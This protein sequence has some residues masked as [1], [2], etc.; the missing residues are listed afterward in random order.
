MPNQPDITAP[1]SR[2]RNASLG[3]ILNYG[4]AVNST[5]GGA[6]TSVGGSATNGGSSFQTV[7]NNPIELV[8]DPN[9]GA[10]KSTVVSSNNPDTI[11]AESV[12]SRDSQYIARTA[13][14]L[15][16]NPN[17]FHVDFP[18]ATDVAVQQTNDPNYTIEG[19]TYPNS[20][21]KVGPGLQNSNVYGGDQTN[22]GKIYDDAAIAEA[23][24]VTAERQGGRKPVGDPTVQN[25][26][27]ATEGVSSN[28]FV[29]NE[30]VDTVTGLLA[31]EY[32]G[33]DT[34]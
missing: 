3:T 10:T 23:D 5:A 22:L 24:P 19:N 14:N 16:S 25:R 2:G 20:I 21:G 13:Q 31:G 26:D 15:I 12:N 18:N 9:S 27:E 28:D 33:A 6:N 1:V 30:D 29:D 8:A 34:N 4:T 7:G 17:G 11:Q 32:T